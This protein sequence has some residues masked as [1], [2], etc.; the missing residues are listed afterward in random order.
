MRVHA[1]WHACARAHANIHANAVRF[2]PSAWRT[3][4][5]SLPFSHT[6]ATPARMHA[7]THT[8]R[9]ARTRMHAR[10][11]ARTHTSAYSRRV[12]I[13]RMDVGVG[14]YA[15]SGKQISDIAPVAN[16]SRSAQ[17]SAWRVTFA[18]AHSECAR[19]CA[20]RVLRAYPEEGRGG[21][22]RRAVRSAARAAQEP[23]CGRDV[24]PGQRQVDPGVHDERHSR[25]GATAV[26]A[27]HAVARARARV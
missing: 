2:T 12:V 21:S 26:S 5:L 14:E 16:A 17:H 27:R 3:R 6:R 25:T 22:E 20:R 18:L 1:C 13:G 23:R 8:S 9:H 7:R 11:H 19:T 4:A 24:R 15:I 10:T